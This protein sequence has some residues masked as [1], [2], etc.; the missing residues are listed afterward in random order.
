MKQVLIVLLHVMIGSAFAQPIMYPDNILIGDKKIPKV[1]VIGTF[2]MSYPNLD[3][4]VTDKDKQVDIHSP[5]KQK[6]VEELVDYIAQFKPTK[7]AV[8]GGRNSGYILR[9]Y[10]KWIKKKGKGKLRASEIDQVAFRLMKRFDMDT[11]YGCN[12]PGMTW[13]MQNGADSSCMKPYLEKV[14]EGYDW[15]SDDPMDSLY[16]VFYEKDD[17]YCLELSLLEYFKQM[18][19]DLMVKRYHGAYLIGDFKTDDYRGA[20][21]LA[22]YWYSR[23][24]RIFRNIQKI[25]DSPDDRIL[26]LFGAGHSSILKQQFEATP[27]FEL[28][29]FNSLGN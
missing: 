29:E 23:N 21:A 12:A 22:L 14:F 6:E 26:V 18:N 7:I 20:D 27:E 17:E 28:V 11:L 15:K 9:R 8:E 24:L 2:H 13:H 1:M 3:A 4:H 10:E 25:T 16:N 5:E 19:S